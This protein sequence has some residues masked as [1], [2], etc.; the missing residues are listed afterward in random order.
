MLSTLAD[1]ASRRVYEAVLSGKSWMK[2]RGRLSVPLA[3]VPISAVLA[4]AMAPTPASAVITIAGT[5]VSGP[6]VAATVTGGAIAGGAGAGL[7]I[8]TKPTSWWNSAGL[9]L[10]V[11]SVIVVTVDPPSGQFFDGSF[12]IDFPSDLLEPVPLQSGW[13]GDWGSD[14]SDPA[15]PVNAGGGFPTATT[16]VIHSPS[17]SLT[18]TTTYNSGVQTTTFDWGAAGSPVET[19]E[20]NFYAAV[21][22]VKKPA[23]ISYLGAGAGTMAGANLFTVNNGFTC[24]ASGVLLTNGCGSATT[25]SFRLSAVPEPST[26]AMMLAGFV[27]LGFAGYARRRSITFG[28]TRRSQVTAFPAPFAAAVS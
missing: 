11:A 27:G 3:L 5:A 19:G 8:A 26:W 12:S 21:F 20:F 15:P 9:S 23:F 10:I 24:S 22:M 25:Q 17:A 1:C 2:R 4:V 13:L 6:A 14:P 28:L 18:T 7:A 16:F